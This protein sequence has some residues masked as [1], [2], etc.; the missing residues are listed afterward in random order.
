MP[1]LATVVSGPG[2]GGPGPTPVPVDDRR[3]DFRSIDGDDVVTWTGL[4]WI[5]LSGITGLDVPPRDVVT[6]RVPGLPGSRLREIRDAERPVVLPFFV[7]GKAAAEHRAQ[8]A[9]LRRLIDYRTLDYAGAEG[10]FDLVAQ[11][12][13]GERALRVVYI[14]GM[15]GSAGY[16]AGGGLDWTMSDV[17]LLA[18]DPYWHGEEWSTPTV[19][20]G[21]GSAFLSN[22]APFPRSISGSVA[23]GASMRVQVGGDVPSPPRI[24]LTAPWDSV[25]ITSPQGLDVTVGAVATGTV[26]IETGRH[27]RVTKNGVAAW[28]LIGDS[29]R[30]Q[31]LPPGEANISIVATGAT[32]ATAARVFGDSLWETAW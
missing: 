16:G 30:W 7:A 12:D 8:M 1:I 9:R 4:E 11:S 23:L 27:R 31:P 5:L 29:P 28:D 19:G 22:S 24:E 20:T 32:S 15:E 2:A 25:H 13:G 14:D 21:T 3:L 17:K 26:L 6:E 18:V 10:T